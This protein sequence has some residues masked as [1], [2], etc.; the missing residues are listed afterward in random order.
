MGPEGRELFY[1][2]GEAMLVVPIATAGGLAPG[3]PEVLFEGR[4]RS[5]VGSGRHY[6]LAPDGQ[7][8]LMIKPATDDTSPPAQIIV[9]E[10]WFEELT[11]RV[12]VP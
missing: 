10:N 5:A 6:D 2:N 4:Y 8:F 9:V 12:P 1:R 3:I 11:A 7:K